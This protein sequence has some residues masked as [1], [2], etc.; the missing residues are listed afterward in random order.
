M[1]QIRQ[2]LFKNCRKTF[3]ETDKGFFEKLLRDF[4]RLSIQYS[5]RVYCFEMARLAPYSPI[6]I[7]AT[8]ITP[9][10]LFSKT[11]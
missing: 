7:T 3:F 1:T 8:L 9:S 10:N 6:H 5:L 4:P 2:R 11:R